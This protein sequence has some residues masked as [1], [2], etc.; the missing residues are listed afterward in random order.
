MTDAELLEMQRS[1]EERRARDRVQARSAAT[2]RPSLALERELK[3]LREHVISDQELAARAAQRELE[4]KASAARVREAA[5]RPEAIT[6]WLESAGVGRRHREL[7]IHPELVP[8]SLRA[9]ADGFPDSLGGSA[10]LA[11]NAGTGK[12]VTARWLLEQAYRSGS[13]SSSRWVCPRGIFITAAALFNAVFAKRPLDELELVEL[14]VL[15][16]VGAPHESGWPLGVLDALIDTRWRECR[17][18]IVTSNLLPRPKLE[19]AEPDQTTFRG[20]YPRVYSRLCD[21]SGPGLVVFAREDLRARRA[22]MVSIV[23][24]ERLRRAAESRGPR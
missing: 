2:P 13:A 9:W 8:A 22:E 18:T 7:R 21:A 23:R 6:N 1:L 20:R 24:S 14:L 16:D 3:A 4:D 12:T 5:L 17:S 11:G 19:Q 15:D 10:L